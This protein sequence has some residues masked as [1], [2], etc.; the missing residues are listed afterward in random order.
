[1]PRHDEAAPPPEGVDGYRVGGG[2]KV[3]RQQSIPRETGGDGVASGGRKGMVTRRVRGTG[4]SG[5]RE[6]G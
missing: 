6:E 1:M 4:R 5:N 2:R 3:G